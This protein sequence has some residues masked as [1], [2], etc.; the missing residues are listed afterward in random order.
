MGRRSFHLLLVG[1]LV[2]PLILA[3]IV[4]LWMGRHREAPGIY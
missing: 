3:A 1:V 2:L 4:G